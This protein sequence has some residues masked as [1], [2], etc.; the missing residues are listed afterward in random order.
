MHT[1]GRRA[2]G[3]GAAALAA[4]VTALLAACEDNP[5]SGGGLGGDQIF[6][7][8]ATSLYRVDL[9]AG[10]TTKIAPLGAAGVIDLALGAD[11]VLYALTRDGWSHIDTSSGALEKPFAEQIAADATGMDVGPDGLL[12]TA[13][14]NDIL[15]YDPL[16]GAGEKLIIFPTGTVATG[17]AAFLGET[18]YVVVLDRTSGKTTDALVALTPL[19]KGAPPSIVG[20]IGFGCVQGLVGHGGTLYGFTCDGTVLRID[21][22]TGRGTVIAAPKV[23]FQGAAGR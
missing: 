5:G 9:Q 1:Q 17:D 22:G 3:L 2:R 8:D 13:Q 6:A 7:H 21:P 15:R 12:Y 20:D 19:Q 16:T 11:G 23:A 18:L 14:G 4:L 10:S